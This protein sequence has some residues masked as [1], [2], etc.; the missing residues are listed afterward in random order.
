MLKNERIQKYN[1]VQIYGYIYIH[2]CN[3]RSHIEDLDGFHHRSMV[4]LAL[5]WIILSCPGNYGETGA[6]RPSGDSLLSAL[7]T[8]SNAQQSLG[9]GGVANIQR[10]NPR[11]HSKQQ[12]GN[13]WNGLLQK[14]GKWKS[15]QQ[16]SPKLR[17]TCSG[18]TGPTGPT[19][20]HPTGSTLLRSLLSII[21]CIS[22]YNGGFNMF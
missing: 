6:F 22:L 5:T 3:F 7:V 21:K 1:S 20:W 10:E 16:N 11:K 12:D 15:K 8:A 17:A 9:K 18:T 13:R 19:G 2:I 14:L 4:N